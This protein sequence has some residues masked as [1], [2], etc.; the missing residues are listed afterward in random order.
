M[1]LAL[2]VAL[3]YLA[4]AIRASPLDKRFFGVEGLDDSQSGS[5]LLS[6][7]VIKPNQPVRYCFA[8]DRSHQNLKEI[9]DQAIA[10][11]APAFEDSNLEIIPD[12]KEALICTYPTTRVDALII[13]DMTKDN[14]PR[15]NRAPECTTESATTGYDWTPATRNLKRHHLNFCHLDPD[16]IKGTKAQAIRAMTHE[17][18]HVIGLQ[19]EH[20]RPDRNQHLIFN[21]KN[22]PGYKEAQAK[23]LID[24]QAYFEDSDDDQDR[25]RLM[26]NDDVIASDYLP[27]ALPYIG[28]VKNAHR[29]PLNKEKWEDYV[30]SKGF[31][32]D[33]IM[34]YSSHSNIPD[35]ADVNDPKNWI[36]TRK[37]DGK[38]VWQGGHER[39]ADAVISKGDIAR[40]M[41]L[42]PKTGA[43]TFVPLASDPWV[44][45]QKHQK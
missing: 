33:S 22:L 23:A 21:C 9:V 7:P 45:V 30:W 44:V 2:L 13:T 20:Q 37:E 6:W 43:K 12:N 27:A 15:W 17:L 19:H 32:Y 39:A 14:N 8:D 26:C 24:E 34:I 31:D 36:L 41:Q 42:Y 18:G 10:K 4:L 35:S 3:V 38:P 16:D 25:F 5:L 1:H 28:G 29:N 11:W 40:V